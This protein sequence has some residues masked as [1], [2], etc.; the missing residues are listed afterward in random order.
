LLIDHSISIIY[1]HYDKIF[2]LNFHSPFGIRN[3]TIKAS[4]SN[5]IFILGNTT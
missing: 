5:I 3:F 2:N 1:P 4:D